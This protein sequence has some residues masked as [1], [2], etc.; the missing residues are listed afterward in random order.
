MST[1]SAI[2]E[3][4]PPHTIRVPR[5]HPKEPVDAPLVYQTVL[6]IH[7]PRFLIKVARRSAD[8]HRHRRIIELPNPP[9]VRHPRVPTPG[10]IGESTSPFSSLTCDGG[11]LV[12]LSAMRPEQ[13]FLTLCSESTCTIIVFLV[14]HRHRLLGAR[15][16]CATPAASSHSSPL[17]PP[18][19]APEEPGDQESI[20]KASPR[21]SELITVKE[22]AGVD[23]DLTGEKKPSSL[24]PSRPTE[25]QSLG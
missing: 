24:P 25:Q 1:P 8:R 12:P 15:L 20:G 11:L 21:T 5:C 10:I 7:S 16:A 19:N 13:G 18:S 23:I 17:A 2:R 22:D 3:Q 9:C 6:V 14:L 4:G